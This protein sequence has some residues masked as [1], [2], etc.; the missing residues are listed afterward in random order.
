MEKTKLDYFKQKL[1]A[2]KSL[3]IEELGE[4]G[5]INPTNPKD[6]EPTYSE[7]HPKIGA[8]ETEREP[9]ENDQGT[10][11][12]EYEVRNATEAPL[13]MRFNNVLVALNR[14]KDGKYGI[15]TVGGEPHTIEEARLEA[16]P[17]AITCIN[18]K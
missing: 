8:D 3:L 14:I 13:E 12:E 2:E 17:A 16:N 10:Q 6:W 7:L 15:C 11:V 18:H 5:R 1:E 4:L 9:D